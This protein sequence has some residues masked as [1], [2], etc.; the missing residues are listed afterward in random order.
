MTNSIDNTQRA[1]APKNGTQELSFRDVHLH[2]KH[3]HS[4][5]LLSNFNSLEW[6]GTAG[7]HHPSD[8]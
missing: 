7:F 8:S 1:S 2:Y 3:H 6:Y 4:K 5:V